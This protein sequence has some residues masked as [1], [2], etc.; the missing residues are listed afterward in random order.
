MIRK[1]FVFA[2]SAGMLLGIGFLASSSLLKA[3]DDESPLGKVMEKVNKADAALRK[4]TRSKIAF[5]KGQKD[6]AKEVK[7]LVKLAKEAKDMKDVAKKAKEVPNPEKKWDEYIDELVKTTEELGKIAGKDGAVFQ[8]AKDAYGKV[9][10][11]CSDC[12]KDFR[13]DEKF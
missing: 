2:L 4:H 11:V 6:I 3:D 7:E 1:C 10:N 13:V 8:D 5:A 12:H 9:K